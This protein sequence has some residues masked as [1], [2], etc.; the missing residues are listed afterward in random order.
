MDIMWNHVDQEDMTNSTEEN[1]RGQ[2][3]QIA[4]AEA[5]STHAPGPV[6]VESVTVL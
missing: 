2:L 1:D 3:P 4:T 6:N 5:R